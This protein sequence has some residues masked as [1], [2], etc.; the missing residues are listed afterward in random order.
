MSRSVSV[1]SRLVLLRFSQHQQQYYYGTPAT[2]GA[3]VLVSRKS[4]SRERPFQKALQNPT[5]RTYSEDSLMLSQQLETSQQQIKDRERELE[6][7]HR[8]S[9]ELMLSPRLMDCS[10]GINSSSR[11]SSSDRS[12]RQQSRYIL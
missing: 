7:I 9:R 5:S 12:H 10:T 3:P 2:G 6:R 1:S 11:E 4:R 8:R